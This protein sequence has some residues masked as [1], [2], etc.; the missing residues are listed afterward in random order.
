MHYKVNKEGKFTEILPTP[1]HTPTYKR[2]KKLSRR[3]TLKEDESALMVFI[4]YG[5]KGGKGGGIFR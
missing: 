2:L 3:S 5:D 4:V 1:L